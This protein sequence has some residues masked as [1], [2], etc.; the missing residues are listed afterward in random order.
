GVTANIL[1]KSGAW[2]AYNGEKIGQGRDNA[3]EFLRENPALSQEI[4]NK[5]RA[6]LGIPLLAGTEVT[7][8]APKAVSK[9]T[10]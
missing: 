3:R 4:E 9:K 6:S 1:D 10:V 8:T 7:E 5:V 2:Y